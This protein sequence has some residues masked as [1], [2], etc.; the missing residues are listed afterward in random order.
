M[1][2]SKDNHPKIKEVRLPK[3]TPKSRVWVENPL[4]KRKGTKWFVQYDTVSNRGL[5]KTKEHYLG[6][7][8]TKAPAQ[9]ALNKWL[10]T[11]H[12]KVVMC[13]L[14]KK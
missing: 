14:I 12:S 7:W 1:I 11:N 10:E 2:K 13:K 5:V 9:A 3:K 4:T 8:A 6:T